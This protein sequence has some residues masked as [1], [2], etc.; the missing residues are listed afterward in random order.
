MYAYLK[1]EP[2]N[3]SFT[4]RDLNWYSDP[5][6]VKISVYK[7]QDK[8]FEASID[9]DGN[10]TNNHKLG[11]EQTIDIKNPGPGL[12][13]SGVYRIVIDAPIDSVTTNITT[14][15]NK[16]VF[17]GPLYVV[18]NH[19]VYG[20]IITK[21][22]PTK[23]ITNAQNLNFRS[24]HKQSTSVLVDK[25]LVNIATPNQI[26]TATNNSP[27]ALLTIPNSDMIVNG[28]GYF[29]FT[30]DQYFA[31]TSFKILPIN[32]KDDIAQ[33]DYVLTNYKEPDHNG[34]W[35]VSERQFN[36]DNVYIQKGQLGW[37]INA[38]GLKESNSTIEYKQI[39]MVLNKKGWFKTND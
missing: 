25:Q 24:D 5:D 35:L 27:N 22:Q 9:D 20:N 26:F 29:A 18:D 6:V 31:P 11:P 38:P 2:F 37:V 28:S 4:K 21:T 17:E 7:A 15:L 23:L 3:M 8:V 33:T 32:N 30:T 14:N 13:E 16:I 36:L 1:N 34:Y 39:K 10:D 12:P 19:D